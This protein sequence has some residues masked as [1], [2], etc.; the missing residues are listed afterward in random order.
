MKL[1]LLLLLA[2]ALGAESNWPQYRGNASNGFGE[3]SPAV[4]W[5]GAE[6]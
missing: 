5:N 4:E 6:G 3:G 2:T 1:G